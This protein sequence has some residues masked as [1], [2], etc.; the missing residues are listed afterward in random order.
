MVNVARWL[1]IVAAILLSPLYAL[2]VGAG[3]IADRMEERRCSSYSL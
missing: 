3:W 2:W 1:M